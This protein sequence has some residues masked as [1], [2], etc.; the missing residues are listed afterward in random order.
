VHPIAP[1][2]DPRIA[3]AVE[4]ALR[5]EPRDRYA[6][7]IEMREA[8][9]TFLPHGSEIRASMRVSIREAAESAVAAMVSDATLPATPLVVATGPPKMP[10]PPAASPEPTLA[11]ARSASLVPKT[12]P[13]LPLDADPIAAAPASPAPKT[14][15]SA[16]VAVALLLAVAAGL[17]GVYALVRSGPGKAPAARAMPSAAAAPA[18]LLGALAGR[19]WSEAGQ[20]Y[21]GVVTG[22]EVELRIRDATQFPGLGYTAGEAGFVLRAAEGE[23]STFHVEARVR[24][25]PPKGETYEHPR[26]AA[27]CLVSWS[28]INGSPLKAELAIDRLVVQSVQV[29]PGP[30]MFVR[31]PRDASRVTGCVRLADARA[32]ET[33]IVLG[34]TP[35]AATPHPPALHD[36]G[37]GGKASGSACSADAQCSSHRCVGV[38]CR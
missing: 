36:A 34:R 14:H 10:A 4:R 35:V 26:A 33:E 12:L 25:A 24:P 21:N 27:T 28:K 6:S 20:E 3:E 37:G 8:L 22:D 2:V 7:V 5:I 31:D 32:V 19:W 30:G 23:P 17:G 18:A 9:T 1:W 15:T 16:A 29:T 11:P 38:V 13:G